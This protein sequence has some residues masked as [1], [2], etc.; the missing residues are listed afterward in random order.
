MGS[1]SVALTSSSPVLPPRSSKN[2][3]SPPLCTTA[4]PACSLLP[5]S[6]ANFAGRM[7]PPSLSFK[8]WCLSSW[9]NVFACKAAKRLIPYRIRP[10]SAAI[11]CARDFGN[12]FPLLKLRS[13]SAFIPSTC[14]GPSTPRTA[15]PLASLCESSAC[16]GPPSS[17][18]WPNARSRTSRSK[19]DFAIK[20]ISIGPSSGLLEWPRGSTV[21]GSSAAN[22][23]QFQAPV[24]YSQ[25]A[26]PYS[27]RIYD[28]FEHLLLGKIFPAHSIDRRH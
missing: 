21:P 18:P 27:C 19:P 16:D 26:R 3:G 6:I 15:R 4:D 5:G 11:Y 2:C 24:Q 28:Y 25:P 7:P 20:V 9:E 13:A 22:S 10:G 8:G 12:A 17:L 23:V 14:A 1:P